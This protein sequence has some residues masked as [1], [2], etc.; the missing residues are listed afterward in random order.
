MNAVWWRITR[1][2][3]RVFPQDSMC[4]H[5]PHDMRMRRCAGTIGFPAGL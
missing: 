4:V 1:S 3:R 2:N 5:A